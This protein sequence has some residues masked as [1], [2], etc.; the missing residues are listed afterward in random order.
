MKE[1]RRIDDGVNMRLNRTVAMFRDREKLY[2]ETGIRAQSTNP[3]QEAC[4]FFWQDLVGAQHSHLFW[5]VI[6][7]T[8]RN[9]GCENSKL[10]P[11]YG[12]N[13]VL[14]PGRG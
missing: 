12:D 11:A 6:K 3:E 7:M 5:R 10:A 2:A 8:L 9:C 14:Y 4:A 1:Y 13:R